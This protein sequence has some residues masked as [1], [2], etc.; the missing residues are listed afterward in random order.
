[1]PANLAEI[2]HWRAGDPAAHDWR[3]F[4]RFTLQCEGL[5]DPSDED[6][7]LMA[8]ITRLVGPDGLFITA[9]LRHCRSDLVGGRPFPS[10]NV[11]EH[12]LR[13]VLAPGF[14]LAWTSATCTATKRTATRASFSP[15]PAAGPP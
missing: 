2:E 4:V 10:A 8:N 6:E 3:A 5:E 14:T 7:I 15:M 13:R 1:L 12:D 9:A 11:D